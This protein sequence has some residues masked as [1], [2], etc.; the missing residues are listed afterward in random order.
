MIENFELDEYWMRQALAQAD[1]AAAAGDVP[2]G[3]VIVNAKNQI[4]AVGKNERE[5]AQD[6]TA[7]AEIVAL[8]A[9][10]RTLG[11]WR[12][13]NATL[14]CTL[15]PCAMCAGALVN[16]RIRRVVYGAPDAKAGAIDSL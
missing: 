14:Y 2:I 13:E 15:E 16:A 6:P 10:A 5:Q 11:H 7:H 3:A 12:I 1:N 8:R 9:A 4:I